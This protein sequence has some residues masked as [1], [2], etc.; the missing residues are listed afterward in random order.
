MA[1]SLYDDVVEFHLKTR[2][3]VGT[4][5]RILDGDAWA[6]RIRLITEELAELCTAHSRKD[7][8]EFADGLVDLVWVVLGTA[9]EA[10]LPFDALWAE[11]RRSNMAKVGG[12]LDASGKLLKPPGWTP[13][14]IHSVLSRFADTMERRTQ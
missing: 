4:N 1:D 14:D 7:L 6:R 3:V 13:P 12:R 5:P 11:V 2:L 8:A 10:G 9:A